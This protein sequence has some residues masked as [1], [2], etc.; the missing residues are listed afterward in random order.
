M[1]PASIELQKA[2]CLEGYGGVRCRSHFAGV[3]V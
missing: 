1:I 2:H 3:G